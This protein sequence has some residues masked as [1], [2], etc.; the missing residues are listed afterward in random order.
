MGLHVRVRPPNYND[1]RYAFVSV[2]AP[3]LLLPAVFAQDGIPF[4]CWKCTIMGWPGA[5]VLG[6]GRNVGTK[7]AGGRIGAWLSTANEVARSLDVWDRQT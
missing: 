2:F 3:C 4:S 5:A 1:T 7:R 6:A